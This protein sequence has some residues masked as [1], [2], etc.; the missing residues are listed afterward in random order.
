MNIRSQKAQEKLSFIRLGVEG[1]YPEE[2]SWLEAKE[3]QPCVL[4]VFERE[5]FVQFRTALKK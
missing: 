4:N 2:H 5:D 1:D 3:K